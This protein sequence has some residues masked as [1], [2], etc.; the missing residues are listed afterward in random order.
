MKRI[1]AFILSAALCF[2]LV[3]PTA[4]AMFADVHDQATS[5]AVAL[6]QNL[7]IVTGFPDGTFRPGESFTRA[8]FCTMAVLLSGA[9]DATA[10]EGFT[11]FPDVRANHWARGYI[12]AAVRS[13]GIVTGFPDGTFQ[14]DIPISYAQAVTA[15]MRLLGYTDADVGLNWPYGYLNKAAQIGLTDGVS[16]GANDNITRGESAR[17]FYNAI[18]A[19][20][21]DGMRY[22]DT[23]G[24]TEQ[25]AI[26][27]RQ[28]GVSPDGLSRGLVTIGG[29]GFYPYRSALSIENGAQGTLL[30]DKDG[31]ALSWIPDRQTARDITV[32]VIGPMSVSGTD[33]NRVENI[34]SSARVYINGEM[35]SWDRCWI[36]VQ[37]GMSL[38]FFFSASGAVDYIIMYQ[39]ANDDSGAIKIIAT[40]H[41]AGAN[42]LPSL[43]IDGDAQVF[44]NG[45][46]ASWAD[47]RANDV[48]LYD[49][50]ANIVTATDFR[51]TGVYESA[52]PS[53]EAPDEVVT[54]GGKNFTLLPEVRPI[55]A[56][57]RIGEALTFFFTPDGR[58][59]DIRSVAAPVSQPGITTGDRSV[60]LCNGMIISGNEALPREFGEGTPVLACMPRPGELSVEAIPSGAS[61]ELDLVSMTAGSAVI[62]PYAVIIDLSYAGG[63]AVMADISSL[64]DTVA[65]A[66]VLSV[67]LDTAGRANLIVLRNVTGNAWL[68]GFT[69]VERGIYEEIHDGPDITVIQHPNTVHLDNQYSRQS[70]EDPRGLGRNSGSGIYGIAIGTNGYVIASQPCTRVNNVSRSDFVGDAAVR[71]SGAL[72]PIMDGLNVYVQATGQYIP[73]ADARL[74]SNNFAVFLDKPAADGGI[75]RFIIAF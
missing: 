72:R 60:L 28:D 2:C 9:R 43:G 56:A 52:I 21:K 39:P 16:L 8:Q 34:P 69:T 40:E 44:K 4:N 13:L 67:R 7:G 32:R 22:C 14:P 12:N 70:F 11:I 47:L 15:L 57:R 50:A 51:I 59:A 55:L 35:S 38:R 42:P 74:Y 73:I 71:V 58:V 20:G 33:G 36:D 10:Y 31:Y 3:A 29:D 24:F 64:P 30:V 5:S 68:Y 19:N 53:R 27:L 6:L 37:A 25:R 17:M 61:A 49:E 1:F 66:S 46:V 26:V 54:L 48:L 23:L 65:A 75:P 63:R 41:G 62:A 18:F 45:V